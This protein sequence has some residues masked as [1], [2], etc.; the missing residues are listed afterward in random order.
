MKFLKYSSLTKGIYCPFGSSFHI[1][2][3]ANWAL[4]VHITQ[5]RRYQLIREDFRENK[6]ATFGDPGEHF[7]ELV[8]VREDFERVIVGGG[9][10]EIQVFD[11]KDA[12]LV[13]ILDLGHLN[14][15]GLYSVEEFLFVGLK[16]NFKMVNLNKLS[17]LDLNFDKQINLKSSFCM[18]RLKNC[19]VN[20][21]IEMGNNGK[22]NI[23]MTHNN[24][25]SLLMCS[26]KKKIKEIRN[27]DKILE[28]KSNETAEI[29][30]LKQ[31]YEKLKLLNERLYKKIDYFQ[32]QLTEE[33]NKN[34]KL[35][36]NEKKLNKLFTHFKDLAEKLEK[37][38]YI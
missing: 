23:L 12:R 1:S 4:G 19:S 21:E 34:K 24:G 25:I 11:L 18:S 31:K 20:E 14:L 13:K 22:I 38:C 33:I 8:C 36:Q 7:M 10:Q 27:K 30:K 28:L 16:H 3:D 26:N 29:S 9:S 15:T 6:L 5:N 32:I 2:N 37:V 17:F 35:I